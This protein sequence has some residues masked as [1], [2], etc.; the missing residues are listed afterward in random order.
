MAKKKALHGFQNSDGLV[1]I[2]SI[3]MMPAQVAAWALEVSVYTDHVGYKEPRG[4]ALALF[5]VWMTAK[6]FTWP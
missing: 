2:F 6:F 4:H 1:I 5:T 3:P